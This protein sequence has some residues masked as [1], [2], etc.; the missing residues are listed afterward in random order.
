MKA[1]VADLQEYVIKKKKP[2]KKAELHMYI[3]SGSEYADSG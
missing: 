3:E 2:L 1:Y